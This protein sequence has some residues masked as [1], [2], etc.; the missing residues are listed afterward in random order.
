MANELDQTIEELEAEVLK[1]LEEANGSSPLKKEAYKPVKNNHYDVKVTVSDRDVDKV[2]SFILNSPEYDNGEIE[3]VDSDQVDGSGDAF[4]GKGDIFIQGDGAGSLGVDLQKEFGRKIK[5]MGEGAAPGSAPL[6]KG[7]ASAEPMKKIDA[8]EGEI[9]DLGTPVVDPE[10]TD[11][12]GKKAS[13]KSK[14]VKD[15]VTKNEGKPEPMKKIKEGMHEKMTK[16]QMINAMKDMMKEM[17]TDHEQMENIYASYH[18][19]AHPDKDMKDTSEMSHE[20]MHKE[21]MSGADKM[22]KSK[23][24]KLHAAYH[25][26]MHGE[27]D[28]ADDEMMEAHIRSI[29]VSD[30]VSALMSGEGDLSEEFKLKAATVFEAA[31]KAKVREELTRIQEDYN[32]ELEETVQ[33]HKDS[34]VEKVDDY[35]NYAVDEWMNENELAIERGLKGE[36]AEDFIGGLRQLFEDHYVDV[37]D[38]KYDVLESQSQRIDELEEKLNEALNANISVKKEN[39]ELQRKEVIS[40]LSED[41]TYTEIEKFKSLVEDVEFDD[42]DTYTTKLETL[43]ESYFPNNVQE[44]IESVDNVDAG[45]AQD[46]DVSDSMQ[47]Y[48]TALSKTAKGANN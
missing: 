13:A 14:E 5:V 35:L 32:D 44:V 43:K 36:I 33:T 40:S 16:R 23:V 21:M 10:S 34:L 30:H 45:P 24:E 12:I 1:E 9:E 31:V 38:E 41:L 22:V 4:R 2:K 18:E 48:L 7:A 11:S 25:E 46:I 26:A 28:D 17:E 19:M 6:K 42:K 3:D 29:D 39:N 37:P 8:D 47:A 20:D 27:E 15:Q